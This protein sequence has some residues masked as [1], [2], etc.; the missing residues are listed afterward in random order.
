MIQLREDEG[1]MGKHERELVQRSLT[2]DDIIVKEIIKPRTDMIAVEVQ[3]P[4]HEVLA[5]FLEKRF[6][7]LPVYE[8]QVDNVIGILSERDFLATYIQSKAPIN[9]R[10]LVREPLFVVDSK[11]SFRLAQGTPGKKHPYGHCR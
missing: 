9:L 2:F 1:E 7:R 5:T 4:T 8:G 11:K 6:S 3:Q 10:S